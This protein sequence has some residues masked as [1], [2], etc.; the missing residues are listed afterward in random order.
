MYKGFALGGRMKKKD[1]GRIIVKSM[2]ALAAALVVFNSIPATALA[3]TAKETEIQK[4]IQEKQAQIKEEEKKKAEIK[5]NITN[6][7]KVKSELEKSKADLTA[8]VRELDASVTEIMDKIEQ[9]QTDIEIKTDEIATTKKELA[10]AEQVRDDQYAAMKKRVQI[11]YEQG[12]DY[13]LELLFTTHGFGDF[14]NS[15]ENINKLADYDAKMYRQYKETV[16]Y[17]EAVKAELEAE[18][19]VLQ[20]NKNAAEEEKKA[21]EELIEAKRQQIAEYQAD[22]NSKSA[23]IEEFE[24]D[25]AAENA[26]I[27]ELEK[28]VAAEQ[29]KLTQQRVYDGGAFCWPAPSY[30]RVSS[31]YGYRIHPILGTNKF[32]NGVDLAAPGGSDILAAYGGVVVGAA[33]ND[34]MGNYVMIDHGGGLYTIYMHASK[35]LVSN[36]QSVS[37]GQRIALVGTTGRSTGNHLHFSVRLNGNYVSPWNYIVR[38]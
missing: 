17:V 26:V 11:L 29:A 33:Y 18:E 9:L 31:E 3:D 22:I 21:M 20:E 7:K 23:T 30:T 32:H 28:A 5:Q 25:L 19:E 8:Y 34:S 38:P 35:L 4:N 2:A 15:M 1:F 27:S 24:H 6:V 37:R 12:D 16:E 14:L 13:Y 10:D 36:G